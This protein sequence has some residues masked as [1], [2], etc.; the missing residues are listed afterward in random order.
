[1]EPLRISDD[2]DIADFDG[3]G[4]ADLLTF[5]YA[6]NDLS[7]F[8]SDGDGNLLPQQRYGIGNKPLLGAVADFNA[9]GRMDVAAAI[10]LPPY[11]LENALVLLR[12]A[13]S[14]PVALAVDAAGNGVFEPNETV[15]VAPG[16][17][18]TG[19]AAMA[20]AGGVSN[21]TGP[22]GPT[23][24]IV[25][26]SA[27]YGTIASGESAS[28]G[29]DCY[30]LNVAASSRPAP[31]W[32]ATI[33]ET[34]TPTGATKTWTLHVGESFTDVGAS[35]SFYR[36]IETLLHNRVTGGC[37]TD[38]Y[39]PESAVT[40]GQ[41]AVFLLKAKFGA[42]H[43]PPAATGTVFNDV[44]VSHLF[45]SWIEE[46]AGMGI[47]GGCGG[48]NYCPAAA[49]TRE[50][51]AVFLLKTYEG[52]PYTPPPAVGLFGDVPQADV[53]ASWIEELY[54]RQVTGGCQASPLLYC[55]DS[56][57]TRGQMAVFLVK[58]FGLQLYQP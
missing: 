12:S 18:N 2:L 41:M 11:G 14:E 19:T 56:Q 5:N 43:V 27:D 37:S 39:C 35:H 46:L 51:M 54:A 58:T 8:L 6:S 36:F 17:R 45:A 13:A 44:P 57:N 31:H 53:F 4:H 28:C 23:Y 47:T 25:D 55:P 15:V 33:L 26:A 32:D 50:Q 7:V 42:D 29:P 34:V 49:V 52:A 22:A 10:G 38:A 16:W 48:G 3:D 9:D 21:F 40:R 24:S 30:S 1:V 20:V